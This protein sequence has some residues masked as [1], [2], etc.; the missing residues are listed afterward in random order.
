VARLNN[1]RRARIRLGSLRL[2]LLTAM[3]DAYWPAAWRSGDPRA[4]PAKRGQQDPIEGAATRNHRKPSP[5]GRFVR[6]CQ[7]AVRCAAWTSCRR[8]NTITKAPGAPWA[9]VMGTITK[10]LVPLP[11]K[12]ATSDAAGTTRAGGR[13]AARGQVARHRAGK[14]AEGGW[15]AAAGQEPHCGHVDT[16]PNPAGGRRLAGFRP[17]CLRA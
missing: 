8:S 3:I 5:S 7:R 15:S 2:P 11:R 13:E 16:E 6:Y 12:D 17:D 1:C 4:V 14:A 10:S 9:P